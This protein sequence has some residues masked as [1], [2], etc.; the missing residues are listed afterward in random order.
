MY[1]TNTIY[2]AHTISNKINKSHSKTGG[3]PV[4]KSWLY[5]I[6]YIISLMLAG[7]LIGAAFI[8][9]IA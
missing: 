2:T 4:L 3:L 8:N 5:I 9:L 7:G 6:S 1:Q